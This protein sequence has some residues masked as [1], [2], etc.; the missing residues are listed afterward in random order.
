MRKRSD[1]AK[2]LLLALTEAHS[3]LVEVNEKHWTKKVS[4]V[5]ESNI[6][7][8]LEN[9]SKQVLAW[10]GGVGSFS[11]LIISHI[12]GHDVD[13]GKEEEINE[14]FGRLRSRIW[15]LAKKLD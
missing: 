7:N 13:Q 11:D 8:R 12:N 3:L 14:H 4:E 1:V 10:Y 15:Q 6:E 5:V 9:D 2:E